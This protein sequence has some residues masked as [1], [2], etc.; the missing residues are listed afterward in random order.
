M[1]SR[2]SRVAL[3]G[4]SRRLL[5]WGDSQ[6]SNGFTAD[7]SAGDAAMCCAGSVRTARPTHLHQ[8]PD[9]RAK[10]PRSGNST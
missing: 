9:K 7:G 3:N 4:S 6:V 10:Y 1:T 5:S 2:G 8:A